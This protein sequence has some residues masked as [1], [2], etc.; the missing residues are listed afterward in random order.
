MHYTFVMQIHNAT[1]Y[2][3][4]MEVRVG[5]YLRVSTEN[6]SSDLQRSDIEDYLKHKGWSYV[7][8]YE[9]KLS[10]TNSRRPGLQRLLNDIR[11]KNINTVICWKLDRFFRSIKDLVTTLNELNELQVNFISLRDNIDLSTPSGRL[12]AHLLGSIAQFESELIKMRVVAG[13]NEA[14]K[15]G[16]RLGRP[17]TLVAEDIILLRQQGMSLGEI[18]KRLKVS[19]SGVHKTL[20]KITSKQHL[21]IAEIVSTGTASKSAS[22]DGQKPLVKCTIY[23][24]PRSQVQCHEAAKKCHE[25]DSSVT[26]DTDGFSE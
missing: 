5:V 3:I 9:D 15:K 21:Q 17:T 12:L 8:Y 26:D 14:R 13:L 1:C 19:K 6:Q 25:G 22:E 18:A 23:D 20:S 2:T 7:V 10:G 24:L 16:I 11:S 4:V